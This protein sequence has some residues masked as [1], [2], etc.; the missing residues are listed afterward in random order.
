VRHAHRGY[1]TRVESSVNA[2]VRKSKV[3]QSGPGGRLTANWAVSAR[4]VAAGHAVFALDVE[5][6]AW[7]WLDVPA[8]NMFETTEGRC[9]VPASKT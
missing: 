6:R 1:A 3:V 4:R 8:M 2:V 9:D 5:L 7:L